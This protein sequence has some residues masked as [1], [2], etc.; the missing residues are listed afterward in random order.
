MKSASCPMR[1]AK[2]G[3]TP[4]GTVFVSTCRWSLKQLAAIL[5]CARI[6]AVHSIVFAGFSSQALADRINDAEAKVVITSDGLNRG[7]KQV[8][9]KT[10]GRR[11]MWRILSNSASI[12]YRTECD[13]LRESEL[14]R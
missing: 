14:E 9:Y 1:Y 13:K 3:D 11:C 10:D 6:G 2:L 12:A 7:N 8:E 5:A 4:K